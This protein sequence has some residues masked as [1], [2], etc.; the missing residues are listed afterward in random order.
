M[1][2]ERRQNFRVEWKS[3]AAFYDGEGRRHPC[4]VSDLSNGGAKI[5]G[6]N[7]ETMPDD[8]LL[9]VSPHSALRT[10][11]IA[12]RGKDAVGVRFT[13][14]L[15]HVRTPEARSRRKTAAI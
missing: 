10:C 9:L 1:R 8:F 13:D 2:G 5:T 3:S 14:T 12:W 7:P 4:V 6:A 15:G 11:H